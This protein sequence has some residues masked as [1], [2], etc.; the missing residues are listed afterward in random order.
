MHRY[1]REM[2]EDTL[3]YIDSHITEELSAGMLASRA[4]FSTYHFCRV[5]QVLVGYPVMGYVRLRRLSFAANALSSGR[6]I[7]DIAMDY[8]FE[9]HS[10]FSKAFRRQFG[11]SPEK[12]RLHAHYAMP[13]APSLASIDKYHTGG[14]VMEPKFVALESK[15]I[16]GYILRTRPANGENLKAIPEFW[17][18]YL[19]EGWI[20]KLHGERFVKNHD[21]YGACF[22]ESEEDG[23][24]EYMIGVEFNDGADIPEGYEVRE[25]PAATY[26]VFDTPPADRPS[27]SN[28]IQGVW[29]YILGEWMPG[30]G[31]EYAPGCVDYELYD[32]RLMGDT[33]NVCSIYIP[34]VKND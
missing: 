3:E 9:T 1:Y 7:I 12:Y 27:F 25:I 14:I 28:S 31:Y 24:F 32:E 11:C 4:G 5:F 21:E 34:V 26:A 23:S 29:Q 30:S 33:G 10:G 16:A 17:T 8:G 13:S 22:P 19:E 6:R 18:R 20:K 2:L 15:K